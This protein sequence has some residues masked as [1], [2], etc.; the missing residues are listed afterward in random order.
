MQKSLLYF[1]KMTKNEKKGP[2]RSEIK[3]QIQ[4]VFF[5]NPSKTYNYK[6]LAALLGIVKKSG[7][8]MVQLSLIELGESG[9]LSEVSAGRFKLLARGAYITG[10]VDM[11]A[12]GAAYIVPEDGGQDVFVSQSNLKNA[13]NGDIVKVLQFARRKRHTPEG[14][15]VEI[16]KRKRDLFVGT[17]E[18]SGSF[19]FLV[20]DNK[21]MHKDIFIPLDKLKGAQNGQKVVAKII[22]WPEKAKN[23]VGEVVDV[24]GKAGENNAEMHAIL[25]EFNLPYMYPPEV[26]AAAENI[27]ETITPEEIAKRRDFRGITTFTIDPAD[28]KDFDDALSIRKLEDGL[29]EVGVHIADVT[30]YV[31]PGSVI[32]KEGYNRATS[33]Y[34]VD[35]VVP[36]LP[37]RLSNFLCSLRPNEEKLCFSAVFELTD[38]A[39]IRNQWIGRTVIK[40]DRRFSYEEAQE[41][42]ETGTG[43]YA[44]ELK[45]LDGLAKK[46][47]EKRFRMGAI[48]FERV[49]VKFEIDGQGKPLAVFFKESKDSNKLIEEFMLLANKKVA[50][51]VG[52]NEIDQG[53]KSQPKTF[54][55][56]I[57][58]LPDPDKFET[59]SKFV[60]KFGLEAAPQAKESISQSINRLLGAVQG[61]K[62]QNIVETL[63]VR[64]MAKAIY[65]THNIG[66]YGLAFKH[67]THFTSPIRRY[68]DMMVHRLL[69]KYLDGGR[70]VLAEKY[71]EMCEHSS[72]M[73]QRSADAERASIK[74]KQVEFLKEKVG[75]V[76]DGVISGVTE[77]GLYVELL[78]NK[79]EGMIPIRDLDDDFYQFD[80]ENYCLVGRGTRKKYQL[81]D[82]VKIQVARANLEK[83]QLD[84]ALYTS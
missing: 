14:E 64:T 33:V 34:L 76:F 61:R 60:R 26:D 46:L 45:T 20:T 28:A 81:G 6:Q 62:E 43:D 68:P 71:E 29:W 51:L 52:K 25:A 79:C 37:E 47:R 16:V 44:E 58:D 67:Y 73:E 15:V 18:I 70:S 59:F 77:W 24:L 23:P 21:V 69:Q 57:H 78:E 63:A 56:R 42:L 2:K 13:L 31:E 5:N 4:D 22:E 10:K 66:H 82:P 11:T 12:S 19:A 35:R 55:Y 32:D 3:P 30:H 80:E 38:D 7:R 39:A 54:V 40:S 9:F 8:Q 49:E 50:E 65:S 41:V 36:M 17:L 1:F 75:Q 48:G 53:K 74:Y 83:R 72:D 27:P 84:F